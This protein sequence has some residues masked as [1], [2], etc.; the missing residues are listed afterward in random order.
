MSTGS[1]TAPPGAVR[2]SRDNIDTK[3]T[4]YPNITSESNGSNVGQ[5]RGHWGHVGRGGH[6]R[7]GG[8][9]GIFNWP[10]YTPYIQNFKG[11]V[12]NFGAVLGT[13]AEQREAKYQYKK[14]DENMNQ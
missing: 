13:T 12:E 14:F 10:L 11:E 8:Q 4:R 6:H 2:N 3:T 1:E 5:W 9:V 7:P